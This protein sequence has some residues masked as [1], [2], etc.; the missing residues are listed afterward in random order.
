MKKILV[1]LLAGIMMLSVTACKDRDEPND[2][3][4]KPSSSQSSKPVKDEKQ[5][6]LEE[7]LTKTIKEQYGP[8]AVL[9][10]KEEKKINDKKCY[11]YTAES[12]TISNAIIAIA[13][14]GTMYQQDA[15]SGSFLTI[16]PVLTPAKYLVDL[17][18]TDYAVSLIRDINSVGDQIRG[19]TYKAY[20]ADF[21]DKSKFPRVSDTEQLIYCYNNDSYLD[22]NL[23]LK[24]IVTIVL[25]VENNN[26]MLCEAAMVNDESSKGK[27]LALSNF[28]FESSFDLEKF[29]KEN[30]CEIQKG[31]MVK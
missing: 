25:P 5:K 29:A 7:Q 1:L 4:S 9:K 27:K 8:T 12:E 16:E 31:N 11:V 21:T 15:G 23:K 26:V 14:D 18:N 24:N 13:E 19:G 2:E 22:E 30:N 17:L 6:K 10:F 3:S 28:K 20:P